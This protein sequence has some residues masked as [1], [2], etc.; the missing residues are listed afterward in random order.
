MPLEVR[1][2]LGSRVAVK[3]PATFGPKINPPEDAR[4]ARDG[5]DG[6]VA[7][8]RVVNPLPGFSLIERAVEAVDSVHRSHD[9]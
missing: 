4:I 9:V 8:S 1:A 5:A 2:G 6:S 7:V 3:D